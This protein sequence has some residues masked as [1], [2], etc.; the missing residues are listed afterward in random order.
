MTKLKSDTSEKVTDVLVAAN[1]R[2]SNWRQCLRESNRLRLEKLENEAQAN[3]ELFNKI[4]NKWTKAK[5]EVTP[6]ELT[7]DLTEQQ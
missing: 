7:E 2:E 1:A 4:M 5:T 6:R 3:T